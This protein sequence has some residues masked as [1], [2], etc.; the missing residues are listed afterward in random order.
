MRPSTEALLFSSQFKRLYD[1]K[2]GGM[3]ESYGLTPAE[4]NVLLF[5]ANNPEYDTAKDISEIR[6]LPKSCVS[7]AV[8]SL[9]RQGFLKSREDE[10]DRR[11]LHLFIPPAAS[12]VVEDAQAKQKEFLAGAFR[13][14]TEEERLA[15]DALTE[16]LILNIKEALA[17]C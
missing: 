10:K 15:M 11:V 8:D 17:E 5:L 3:A 16:K 13:N 9:I 6:L 12:G 4:V 7:K 2:I 14:F 1:K